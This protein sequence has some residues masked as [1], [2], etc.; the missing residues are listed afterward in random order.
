MIDTDNLPDVTEFIK[1]FSLSFTNKEDSDYYFRYLGM[2]FRNPSEVIPRNLC[3]IGGSGTFKTTFFDHLVYH[4]VLSKID[5]KD[6]DNDFDTWKDSQIIVIDE[7]PNETN[8]RILTRRQNTLKN[9]TSTSYINVTAK[10][11]N[12]Q[13]NKKNEANIIINSNFENYGGLF[14]NQSLEFEIFR[15]F[16][17]L[18][19]K[20]FL[21]HS[22]ESYIYKRLQNDT[23]V[24]ALID[25]LKKLPPLTDDELF[26]DSKSVQVYKIKETQYRKINNNNSLSFSFIKD[27]E[28][29]EIKIIEK[30]IKQDDKRE[31]DNEIKII[32]KSK[33]T[34]KII[35]TIISPLEKAELIRRIKEAKEKDIEIPKKKNKHYTDKE[36]DIML[37]YVLR[38][39][40]GRL[41]L[42]LKKIHEIVLSRNI[43]MNIKDIRLS[44]IN[45]EIMKDESHRCLRDLNK[46]K[47]YIKSL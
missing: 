17:I 31:E 33:N 28:D 6:I 14:M 30:T 1:R 5:F 41:C 26:S 25:Y 44:L 42:L 15:R 39:D 47:E 9:I 24:Y 34:K 11:K 38:I 21:N 4:I 20:K 16:R 2:K 12:T 32:E 27:E 40:S 7:I 29:N 36:I 8:P 43:Q 18:H 3:Q 13:Y 22:D 37:P 46:L 19:K 45:K 23:F 35:E 10:H